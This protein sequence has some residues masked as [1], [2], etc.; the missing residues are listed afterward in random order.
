MRFSL[1]GLTLTTALCAVPLAAQAQAPLTI[2]CSILEGQCRAGVAAFEKATGAKATMVRKSTGETLAQ[3][4]AEAS[5]PRADVW[6]GGPGDSHIQA[7]EEGLTVEYKSP[8]LPE[9]HDWAQR[10]A[11]QAKYR[12]TGTYLGALGIGYNT[13]VLASRGLP[14]PK[15]WADLL[16]PKYRDEVQVSDPNSSGTAYVFLA[17]LVQLMG[18]DKAFDYMKGL[19]K[20]VNQY[21]KSG[22][23]PV[24]AVAL[25]ETGIAIAFMHD[26]VTMIADGAP[27]KTLAPCEGTG[28]ETGSISLV[29]GGKNMETAQKFVD[30]ALSAEAQK[31][32]GADMKIYSIASN[33]NAPVSP[34]AP[35]LSE[36]K[37]INYD[38]AKYGSVAGLIA[39]PLCSLHHFCRGSFRFSPAVTRLPALLAFTASSSVQ[40]A[41]RT[42]SCTASS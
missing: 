21:T 27:V 26:M 23:A 29:K 41:L 40:A 31:L 6:W 30:W 33:K 20:N 35:K 11:E 9:L 3:I 15:C 34:D 17:S 12:A 22:A 14:E 8:K 25:G 18:E 1:I 28:Y 37:L 24:K 38:T 32:V 10:F 36:M 13:K 16:D 2:Y 7:A 19:H 42:S 39:R 4:R 5:N